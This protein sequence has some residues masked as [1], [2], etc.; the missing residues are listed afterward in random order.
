MNHNP[1]GVMT[2]KRLLWIFALM[3]CIT[4]AFALQVDNAVIRDDPGS[5]SA[6]FT[7][8]NDEDYRIKQLSIS[9]DADSDYSI[10]FGSY[11]SE[12]AKDDSLTVTVTGDI[13]DDMGTAL[14]KIGTITVTGELD[15]PNTDNPFNGFDMFPESGVFEELAEPFTP[16]AFPEINTT[17]SDDCEDLQIALEDLMS[18][19]QYRRDNL[20]NLK[21]YQDFALWRENEFNPA[22][23]EYMEA[24][25]SGSCIIPESDDSDDDSDDDG[26]DDPVDTTV[27]ATADLKM[28]LEKHLVIDRLKVDCG[29]DERL[30]D[31]DTLTEV[32]PG[33][34]CEIF[35]D[36]ENLYFDDEDIYF[37]EVEV[38][39]DGDRYVD[40]DRATISLEPEEKQTVHLTSEVDSDADDRDEDITIR[41]SG[42]DSEGRM[43]EDEWTI[44]FEIERPRHSIEIDK[45]SI[46]PDEADLCVDDSVEIVVRIENTGSRD[47]DEAA[48]EVR[49]PSL[50]FSEKQ[51]DI[52]VDEG[53]EETLSFTVDLDEDR[54]GTYTVYVNT[55]YDTSTPS[56]TDTAQFSVDLCEEEDEEVYFAPPPVPEEEEDEQITITPEPVV[57]AEPVEESSPF[58]TGLLIL[59]NL[60]VLGLLGVLGVSIAKT[61]KKGK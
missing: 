49:V 4:S 15:V 56:H 40:D 1:Y 57:E 24:L 48:V 45:I 37:D 20:H 39:F 10:A 27:T 50:G 58:Y 11:P 8:T 25:E 16:P 17:V 21:A 28:A 3:L 7:I 12:L 59:A 32:M 43:H 52:S 14:T 44:A 41:V 61:L 55:F 60:G 13:P 6:T 2:M 53:D 9:T 35:I 46:V 33:S 23:K 36:V 51:R 29:D 31:G 18:V 22:Y 19:Y 42:E 34:V 54:S 47:E 26:S 30:D 38:E 5:A